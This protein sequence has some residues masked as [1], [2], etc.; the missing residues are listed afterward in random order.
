MSACGWASR[1]QGRVLQGLRRRRPE[2]GEQ[3][4]CV[5]TVLMS[6]Q[7]VYMMDHGHVEV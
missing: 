7:S 3:V 5:L 2:R 4:V 6:G 1:L